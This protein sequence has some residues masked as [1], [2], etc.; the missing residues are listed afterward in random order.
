MTMCI[1]ISYT[2]VGLLTI[3][4][5]PTGLHVSLLGSAHPQLYVA[6]CIYEIHTWKE[7]PRS[8]HSV[9]SLS[10]GLL[11]TQE[12]SYIVLRPREGTASKTTSEL[13]GKV[14]TDN[15][16]QIDNFLCYYQY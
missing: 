8:V 16:T 1:T 14:W 15:R 12:V 3:S 7:I 10:Q 11:N 6:A 5:H 9:P 13:S 4:L 2:L